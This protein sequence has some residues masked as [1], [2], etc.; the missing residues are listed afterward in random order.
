[1]TFALIAAMLV[2]SIP[3][4][5]FSRLGE[6]FGGVGSLTYPWQPFTAAFEHG[7]SGFPLF[8]HLAGNLA[9]IGIV[10]V[11]AERAL[12]SARYLMVTF[13]AIALSLPVRWLTGL[14]VN[15]SSIFIYA[16]APIAAIARRQARQ[17]AKTAV[18]TTGYGRLQPIFFLMW[19]VIPLAMGVFVSLSVGRSAWGLLWGNAFHLSG[20]LAGLVGG[21]VFRGEI[22]SRMRYEQIIKSPL[23]RMGV[24]VSWA[25]PSSLTLLLGLAA[26]GIL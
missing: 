12:G 17:E 20:T 22:R 13:L 7:W 2:V 5:L 24:I 26:L 16:Y 1:V 21:M 23:D 9:L 6:V 25:I 18:R 19:G 8:P 4:M 3:T 15:G 11:A 10:G 14:D